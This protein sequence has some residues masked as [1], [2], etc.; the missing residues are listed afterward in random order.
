MRDEE[1]T[2]ERPLGELV[3]LRQRIAEL[4]GSEATNAQSDNAWQERERWLRAVFEKTG[5]GMVISDMEG[6]FLEVN[7]GFCEFIGYDRDELLKKKVIDVTY[8]EDLGETK[9]QFDEVAKKVRS[10]INLEKRYIRKDGSTVWGHITSVS[11]LNSDGKPIYSAAVI[12]NITERKRAEEV[13]SLYKLSSE[14]SRDIILSIRRADGRILEANAA[15]VKAYGY[16]RDEILGLTVHDLR[17]TETRGTANDQMAKADT[18]GLLFETVHQRK[19]GSTF[20]VEVSSQG[21]IIGGIRV[22]ISVVRDI[23]ERRLAEDA[24]KENEERFRSLFETSKDSILIVEQQTGGIIDVNPSA[25]QLWG[26]SKEEL[27]RMKIKDLS[28]EPER[29]I[30]AVQARVKNVPLGFSRKKDGTVFPIEITVSYFTTGGREFH[31]AYVRDIT[32]RKE[33]EATAKRLA[34]ENVVLAEI[35]R[36][37]SS[38]FNIEE[39]YQSFSE[40]VRELIRFDR[41]TI[42]LINAD[43]NTISFPYAEGLFI[44]GREPGDIGPLAGSTVEKMLQTHA[45]MIFAM[46]SEEEVM[47]S[48]PAL[49]SGF[50][51][52]IRSV[53]AVP[54]ISGDR[55]IGTLVLQS[56]LPGIYTE[57]GLKL[58]E[59][60]GNQ[61]AGAIANAKLYG[62][63]KGAEE[64]LR[65]SEEKFR[66]LYDSAPVG[67]HEFD[68]ECRIKNV[69][70]T[71][72][73]MLVYSRE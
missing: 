37:I 1:K 71:D 27:L 24:V 28:T 68:I 52:G 29:T 18:E 7:P 57:Q 49:L 59:S 11:I 56:T 16:R 43:G 54:L 62:S 51:C 58:V 69:N 25:I 44:P 47:S 23:T 30:G 53:L 64:S 31:A 17:T 33:A 50:L 40:K 41:I 26:Y 61:I 21:E 42:G 46:E 13:L 2:N 65:S 48:F 34:H 3:L 35:G 73:E 32:E 4:E 55:V 72:Q 67:Y 66:E 12:Q 39:V 15:A 5:A 14:H 60:I 63:L 8:P 19:D 36:I 38:T 6:N 22:L 9:L 10:S 20:P 70:R 45:G